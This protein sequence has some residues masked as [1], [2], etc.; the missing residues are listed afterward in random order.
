ME[1]GHAGTR[2]SRRDLGAGAV[3]GVL[4]VV[5]SLVPFSFSG[6]PPV[7]ATSV[8]Y[9]AGYAPGVTLVAGLVV[10]SVVWWRTPPSTPCGVLAGVVTGLGTVVCVPVLVGLY[11]F[12]FPVLLTLVT[13]GDV[14]AATGYVSA[15][16]AVGVAWAITVGWCPVVGAVLVPLAALAGGAAGRAGLA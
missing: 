13:G 8:D 10:G 7:T 4:A 5:A 2:P 9:W 14:V 15:E 11:V 12:S 1:T 16:A 6:A 3:A